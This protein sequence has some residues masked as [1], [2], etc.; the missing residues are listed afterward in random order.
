MGISTLTHVFEAAHLDKD[1]TI[2][3]ACIAAN[4]YG[5]SEHHFVL[6]PDDADS[7][8]DSNTAAP[9]HNPLIT[10]YGGTLYIGIAMV[11]CIH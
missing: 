3:V 10:G 7:C 9:T 8:H 6:S 1:C 11:F 5:Q 4:Y 2:R